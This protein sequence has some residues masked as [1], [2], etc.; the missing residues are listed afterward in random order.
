MKKKV[1]SLILSVCL[2]LTVFTCVASA[3]TV[4]VEQTLPAVVRLCPGTVIGVDSKDV[5]SAPLVYGEVYQHGWEIKLVDGDWVPYDGKTPIDETYDGAVIRYFAVTY[6]NNPEDYVYSNEC[7]LTVKHNPTGS[8]LYSGTDHWRVC[9]DCGGN[10]NE[11]LHDFF[12]EPTSTNTVCGV[13]GA[14]RTSQWTGLASFFD[15]LLGY[16]L[17]EI[18]KMFM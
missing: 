10:A 7:Q 4:E 5:L 3:S 1:L 14:K 8:Y 2:L 9:A 11:E 18:L 16:V 13:C 17:G 6:S 12:E 15:W